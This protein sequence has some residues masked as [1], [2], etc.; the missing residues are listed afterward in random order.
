MRCPNSNVIHCHL[1][2]VSSQVGFSAKGLSAGVTDKR[3]VRAVGLHVHLQIVFGSE[4]FLT[5]LADEGS[6]ARVGPFTVGHFKIWRRIFFDC[7]YFPV[8]CVNGGS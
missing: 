6:F 7:F 2:V 4:C 5:N 3:L 1:F 8:K